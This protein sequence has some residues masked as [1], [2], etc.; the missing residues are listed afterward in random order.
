M[1][2][3]LAS[4]PEPEEPAQSRFGAQANGMDTFLKPDDVTYLRPEMHKMSVGSL[5]L[6][7]AGKIQGS[8]L[9]V[10]L[11]WST[12][13]QPE[14]VI[15]SVLAGFN[16]CF[17][18]YRSTGV[19]FAAISNEETDTV[20][21]FV[22][23]GL[24]FRD[25]EETPQEKEAFEKLLRT[26]TLRERKKIEDEKVHREMATEE[27]KRY[28]CPLAVD[29]SQQVHFNLLTKTHTLSLP[30][31]FVIEQGGEVVWHGHPSEKIRASGSPNKEDSMLN[32]VINE[33]LQHDQPTRQTDTEILSE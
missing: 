5:P 32:S 11:L 15:R 4:T 10:I 6:D 25:E 30:H 26:L 13:C 9:C 3:S 29:T 27:M 22:Q 7:D 23:S 24:P 20:R 8:G 16:E 12:W 33:S 14:H 2:R 19:Q 28:P 18:K 21:Q 31:V 1:S 17:K